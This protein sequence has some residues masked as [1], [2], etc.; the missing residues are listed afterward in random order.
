MPTTNALNYSPRCFQRVE[1]IQLL[2]PFFC[3]YGSNISLGNNFYANHNLVILDAAEVS[4]GH[5]VFLGP[6]VGIYTSGYP[7]DTGRRNA[8]LEYANPVTIGSNVWI[9]AGTSILP[10]IS[11]GDDTVVG[12]GSVVN[13]DLP[14]GVVAAGNPCRVIRKITEDDSSREIF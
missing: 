8:G 10:G 2:N 9:G 11:V 4:I 3:D 6:N 1:N 14:P 12:A 5:N 13:R 7:L